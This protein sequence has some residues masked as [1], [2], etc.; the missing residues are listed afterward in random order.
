MPTV[1]HADYIGAWLEVLR[2]DSK[3]TVRAASAASNAADYLLA[4]RGGAQQAGT[5]TADDV[6]DAA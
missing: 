1:R 4:F 2:E 3:A 6:R 5:A